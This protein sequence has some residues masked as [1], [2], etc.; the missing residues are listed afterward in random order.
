MKRFNRICVFLLILG[1]VGCSGQTSSSLPSV[2]LPGAS[3]FSEGEIIY[4]STSPAENTDNR[5]STEG[6]AD[7]TE[8]SEDSAST[9]ASTEPSVSESD[10]AEA[11]TEPQ[12]TSG[13]TDSTQNTQPPTESTQMP[14]YETVPPSE[15]GSVE[16][17]EGKLSFSSCGRYTGAFVEDGSDRP[18][19]NVAAILVSNLTAEYLTYASLQFEINGEAATFVVTGLPAGESAW[20]L[21]YNALQIDSGASFVALDSA[22]QFIPTE[23]LDELEVTFREG[24]LS[25]KNL[26]DQTYIDGYVYYKRLHTDGNYLGGITYRSSIG[27]LAPG[28]TIEVTA[29]H[30]GE[31]LC[32]VVRMTQNTEE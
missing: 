14:T 6:S 5:V 4:D 7:V 25:A 32:R 9:S 26:T 11:T 28:D 17:R 23:D 2:E 31:E 30:A 29:G 27:D 3:Q 16:L 8:P 10:T 22:M 20:V 12:P 24:L 19:E 18:V 1:L 15:D 13:S 21:E